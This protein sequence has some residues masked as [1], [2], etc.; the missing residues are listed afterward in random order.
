VNRHVLARLRVVHHAARQVEQITGMEIE[1]HRDLAL[2][3]LIF[4][5][6]LALEG[7]LDRRVVDDPMLHTLDL[8][9]EDIVAVVVRGEALGLG[10]REVDVRLE[11][12]AD[13]ALQRTTERGKRRVERLQLIEDD[14][15]AIRELLE[16]AHRIAI[17]I[18]RRVLARV[19]LLGCVGHEGHLARKRVRRQRVLKH[20]KRKEIRVV[21]AV[22][23]TNDERLSLEVLG[24][25]C[26]FRDGRDEL[27]ERV[28]AGHVGSSSGA[29]M[30]VQRRTAS[31]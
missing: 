29:S 15:P 9:H 4:A 5:E 7:K 22:F 19:D 21:R 14:G 27:R 23:A 16:D 30:S 12:T 28:R 1:L 20:L 11:A 2:G 26:L 10:R 3:H 18:R 25:E 17:A 31:T 6:G 13:L 8:K 24:K